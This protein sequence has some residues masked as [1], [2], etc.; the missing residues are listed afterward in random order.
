M[1]DRLG[2][3]RS[4]RWLALAALLALLLAACAPAA[5][6]S[7]GAAAPDFTLP[8]SDGGQVSLAD[9][10]GRQPVLLYFHMA[11]G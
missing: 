3:N 5:D 2:P 10:R 1:P 7:A 8:T 6:D 9:Y 11:M 4:T